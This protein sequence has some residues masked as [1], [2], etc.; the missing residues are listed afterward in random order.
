MLI[1][2][3]WKSLAVIT[4][5][6]TLDI[7][8]VLDPPLFLCFIICLQQSL[9]V[10]LLRTDYSNTFPGLFASVIVYFLALHSFLI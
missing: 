8:T 3:G 10:L 6:S 7:A 1:V 9:R 2:N 4:K 5:S